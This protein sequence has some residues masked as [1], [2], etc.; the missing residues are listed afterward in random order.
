[1]WVARRQ[2]LGRVESGA[3][4]IFTAEN[5]SGFVRIIKPDYVEVAE[6]IGAPE[7]IVYVEHLMLGLDSVTYYGKDASK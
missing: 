4:V 3:F 1:M 7:G 6:G 2:D 5:G